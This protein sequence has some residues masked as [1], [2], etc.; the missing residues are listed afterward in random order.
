MTFD[1]EQVRRNFAQFHLYHMIYASAKFKVATTNGLGEDTITKNV[2]DG[3]TYGQ[4]DGLLRKSG[5]NKAYIY[6]D[7]ISVIDFRS[8]AAVRHLG[9]KGEKALNC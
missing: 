7:F 5:Y 9:K 6:I 8:S 2:T 1:L 3:R 4:M